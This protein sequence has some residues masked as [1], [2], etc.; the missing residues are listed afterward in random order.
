MKQTK[1]ANQAPAVPKEGFMK[2][3]TF[4]LIPVFL[5]LALSIAAVYL[6][7]PWVDHVLTLG[8]GSMI[9]TFLAA[10]ATALML[11]VAKT[12]YARGTW[13][14]VK[15]IFFTM[16]LA[17]AAVGFTILSSTTFGGLGPALVGVFIVGVIFYMISLSSETITLI[18]MSIMAV[19]FGALITGGLVYGPLD[20]ESAV[21]FGKLSLLLMLLAGGVWAKLRRY[22]HGVQGVNADGGFGD[23]GDGDGDT[24]DE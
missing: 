23:A 2:Y 16:V 5:S 11:F 20:Y 14:V 4:D 18:G 13:N 15:K 19:V 10:G 7:G 8:I 24:G 3:I 17:S 1:Q 12:Y 22:M 21:F 6:I 9:Y